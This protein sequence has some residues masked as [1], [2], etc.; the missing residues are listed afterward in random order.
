MLFQ[1]GTGATSKIG[2]NTTT[3]ATTLDIKG[4]ATVRG[5]LSLPATGTATVTKATNSQPMTLAASAFNTTSG[6]AV[7]QT[8]QWQAEP[9][10][11]DTATN[12]ATLNLLFGSGTT[13]P[14][15][16][17]L[18][19]ASTGVVTFNAAQTFPNT[20]S[21]VTTAT[22]SG[23]TGGG[24]SGTLNLGLLNTCTT[25]QVLQWNGTSWVCASA[26]TGTV[27]SVASGAGLTG[28]PITGTG[29]LSIA[30]GGVTN[31]M[32]ATSYAQLGAANTFA[33]NQTVNGTLTATSSGTAGTIN[34]TTTNSTASAVSGDGVGSGVFGTA[35]STSGVAVEGYAS[36]TSG[37]TVGVFGQTLSTSGNGVQGSAQ[38]ATGT[39]YGV[40]GVSNSPAGFGVFGANNAATGNAIGVY[41]TSSSNVGYGVEGNSPNIGV[42]GTGSGAGVSG[43]SSSATAGFGV[44]GNSPFI[45]VYGTGLFGVAGLTSSAAGAGVEGIDEASS[46][47]LAGVFEVFNSSATILQGNNGSTTEF[48]V[49]SAGNV[50]AAGAVSGSSF[51]IGGQLFDYGNFGF[52]NAFLGFGGNTTMTGR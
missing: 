15:E 22:G 39:T 5:T 14:A 13:K 8:F 49:D 28:G 12:S 48:K 46:G 43:Q 21:G 31:A 45:G 51:Q 33:A 30:T 47:G 26:G 50:I 38:A 27:T 37:L 18:N 16:T 40:Q 2:I 3:P 7:A 32:L 44:E 41:G 35:T 6:K 52:F 17:G 36:A 23:L 4:S 9:V 20:L 34:A 25:N 42:Y 10:G 29:S 11:N 1:S 24:T 19:I